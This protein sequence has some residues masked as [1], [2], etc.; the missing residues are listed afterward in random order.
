MACDLEEDLKKKWFNVPAWAALPAGLALIVAFMMINN[1]EG[2]SVTFVET[3][4][5]AP[6][7]PQPFTSPSWNVAVHNRGTLSG[8]P[9]FQA[10]HG[11]DCGAPP[12]THTVNSHEGAVFQCRNHVMTS[13]NAEGYGLVYMTPNHMVDFSRGE[14][15]IKFDVSTLRTAKRDWIDLWI[16]PFEDNVTYPLQRWLPDLQGEPK[17]ALTIRMDNGSGGSF[18]KGEIYRNWELQQLGGDSWNTIEKLIET[19]ATKRETFEL[20][21]SRTSVKFGMP[22]HNLWWINTTF[23]DLGWGTGVVQ[24]GHHSYNPL[25]DGGT[26]NTWHWDNVSIS[27]AIPFTIINANQRTADNASPVVTFQ[28]PAPANAHLRFAAVGVVQL[29]YDGGQTWQA[30]TRANTLRGPGGGEIKREAFSSYWHPIPQGVQAVQF[31][32]DRDDW[33]NNV[34][35][36]ESF[37]IW[38]QGGTSQQI[39]LATPA[40]AA[41]ATPAMLP[42]TA[43]TT[44]SGTPEATP[45]SIAPLPLNNARFRTEATVRDS[46]WLFGVAVH[47]TA[48][49]KALVDIQ[50]FDPSGT[51]V[52]R[53]VFDGQDFKANETRVFPGRWK[54]QGHLAAGTYTVKVG[55]HAPGWGALIHW[56]DNAGEFNVEPKGAGA[57]LSGGPDFGDLSASRSAGNQAGFGTP[58]PTS[59][60]SFTFACDLTP[61]ARQASDW[62]AVLTTTDA[63]TV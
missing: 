58:P 49:V 31:K 44:L 25:K 42:T 33:Y 63:S 50:V 40:P 51:Q 22:E 7:S 12:A 28:R 47:S 30:P 35:G 60:S 19:S 15:V 54:Q 38:S 21:I 62:L 6:A 29:S 43:P 4:E 37:S 11:H 5:G 55:I 53:Q 52:H 34:K 14:A 17:N 23:A 20:R 24:L 8:L 26:P 32:F 2:S 13:M 10:H 46:G 36:G 18:F 1:S 56:N 57:A 9:T 48:T 45:S 27:P 3:F 59:T 16:T 61:R 39:V 41:T